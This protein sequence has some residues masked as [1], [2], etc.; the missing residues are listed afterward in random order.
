MNKQTI[1]L[2]VLCVLLA[3]A[4]LMSRVQLNQI[5]QKNDLENVEA[6]PET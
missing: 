1:P 5:I 3:A 2:M 6:L 4:L